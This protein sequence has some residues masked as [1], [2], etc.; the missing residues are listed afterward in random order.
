TIEK[1]I[2][3]KK[4]VLFNVLAIM[5]FYEGF[6]QTNTFPTSG[7]VGIGTTSPIT[8]LQID[9]DG[10]GGGILIGNSNSGSGGY[11]S[12][13]MGISSYKNGWSTIQ[14]I[15]SSG[16]SFGSLL[17]NP[18]GGNVG[19]GTISPSENLTITGSASPT[20]L[21]KSTNETVN[22]FGLM[23]GQTNAPSSY[24]TS[25]GRDL[26]ID[27]GWPN[28]LTLGDAEQSSYGGKIVIPSASV[29]I[30]TTN[31]QSVLSVNGTITATE[32]KITQTGWSDFV[33]DSSY[34]LPSLSKMGAFIK[35]NHHLPDIP[36]T[37]EIENNGLDLGSMEKKQMQKI[38]ELTLYQINSDKRINELEDK[39]TQ[40]QN[41]MNA[42][43][44]ELSELQK[45]IEQLKSNSK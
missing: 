11:T 1:S 25:E 26:S 37:K 10:S 8:N 13:S 27:W 6:S 36:S 41:Q 45:E 38:E 15:S 39:N 42:Y 3:M 34:H 2:E 28:T 29:G 5:F 20:I 19:I 31:P 23:I 16:S 9:P 35:A 12:L 40:L 33:F 18:Y 7:N 30:G 17:L 22:G 24:I 21:I 44:Q 32:V 14:S 43:K 4:I